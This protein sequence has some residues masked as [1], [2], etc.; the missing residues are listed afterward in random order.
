[1][2]VS[3]VLEFVEHFLDGLSSFDS[4]ALYADQWLALLLNV[5]RIRFFCARE[6]VTHH[7]IYRTIRER[8]RPCAM[9][10][11]P[12]YNITIHSYHQSHLVSGDM[13][14]LWMFSQTGSY[15]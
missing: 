9:H 3:I 13:F 2:I 6:A 1:M 12:I 14:R 8:P 4:L 7:T 10:E 15:R 5:P 11:H